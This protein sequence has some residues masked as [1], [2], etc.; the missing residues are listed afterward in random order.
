MHNIKKG[1]PPTLIMIGEKDHLIPAATVQ[2]YKTEMEKVG[3]R[4][5]LVFY[6]G[7]NHGFYNKKE[8]FEPTK[9]EME[10][11]LRSLAFLKL[12]N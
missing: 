2:T 12:T 1:A 4:C 11:F 3:S 5:D 10:K 8:F 7:Q 9:I 6:P